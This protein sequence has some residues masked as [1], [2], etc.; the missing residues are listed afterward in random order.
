[1]V[2]AC[3]RLPVVHTS[4]E[5]LTSLARDRSSA[6]RTALFDQVASLLLDSDGEMPAGAMALIDQIL[7]GLVREVEADV[8]K[9]LACRIAMLDDA[10]RE[11]IRALATDEIEVAEPILAHSPQLSTRDLL[12]IINSRATGHR[13]AIARRAEMPAEVVAALVR[14]K[15]PQVLKALLSNAGAS[16]PRNI[17]NDL[18]AIAESME[19]I[20]VPLVRRDDIPKDLAHQMFWYVSAAMRQSILSRFPIQPRELDGIMAE[21]V[22]ER[23]AARVR[24]FPQQ[25]TWTIGEVQAL[26]AKA[27]SGDVDAFT[28]ALAVVTGVDGATARRIVNDAGGEPLAVACK[29][30]GADRMQFTSIVVQMDKLVSGFARPPAFLADVARTYD[31][32]TSAGARSMLKVWSLHSTPRAA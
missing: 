6:G 31:A 19:Q 25:P 1:M 28:K 11:L 22:A 27:R 13:E 24:P 12:D 17:F 2:H 26:V 20:R 15:E 18:V 7:T 9:K 21:L 4:L 14:L 8:R 32:V 29:A 16:I 5:H 23:G 10:P 30:I 3:G